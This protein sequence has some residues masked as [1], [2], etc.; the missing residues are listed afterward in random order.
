MAT[1][2]ADISFLPELCFYPRH[3]RGWRPSRRAFKTSN[4][5]VSIHATLAGGDRRTSLCPCRAFCV[6]I[7]ATL[8]GGDRA[9]HIGQK[10]SLQFLSTP[11][12]RVATPLGA[13]KKKFLNLF[14]STPPSRVATSEQIAPSSARCVSIHATLAGGDPTTPKPDQTPPPFLSTP[15]SRVATLLFCIVGIKSGCFYPRHPRGWRPIA[16]CWLSGYSVFLSTP[17]SRV[18]TWR[19]ATGRR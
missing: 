3:P 8:A 1:H 9:V 13:H 12:S 5:L 15:P 16:C 4:V 11:P 7:H 2:R 17:P 10:R 18:A 19:N 6:S 14:L